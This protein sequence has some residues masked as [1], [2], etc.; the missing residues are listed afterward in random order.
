MKEPPGASGGEIHTFEVDCVQMNM[1][2]YAYIIVFMKLMEFA[3][4]K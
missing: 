1:I 4:I 3:P 2:L